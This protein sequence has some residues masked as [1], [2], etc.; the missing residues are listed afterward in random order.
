MVR[1]FP[2]SK[3]VES[4]RYRLKAEDA[5]DVHMT[6]GFSFPDVNEAFGLEIRRGVAQFYEQMPDAADVVLEMDRATLISMLAGELSF[7]GIDGAQPETPQAV[8]AA[9][10]E[11]GDVRLTTGT[12]EDFVRFFSYF[13]PPSDQPIP[14]ALK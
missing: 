9:L 13:E 6:M 7:S 12:S 5:L 14:I 3:L 1:A 4:F 2:T 11:S 10:F 8:I